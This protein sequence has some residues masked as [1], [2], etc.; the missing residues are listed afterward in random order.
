VLAAGGRPLLLDVS[1]EDCN[2]SVDAVAG[3][4]DGTVAAIVA[5]DSFGYA[6][7]HAELRELASHHGCALVEDACQSYGGMVD[8][9]PLGGQADIGVISFGTHKSVELHGGGFLLTDNRD[10]AR[11]VMHYL[12]A[13]D[14][15][16]LQWLRERIYRRESLS[17]GHEYR[18]R[19][20]CSHA[21]LLRYRFPA[22]R[23]KMAKGAWDQFLAELS[24]TKANLHCVREE[25]ESWG[26]I[27]TFRYEGVGWLPWHYSF[28]IP[29]EG[30]ANRFASQAAACGLPC[31]RNYRAM[32][33]YFP[34]LDAADGLANAH[35]IA[36]HIFNLPNRTSLESTRE[37]LP[38]VRELRRAVGA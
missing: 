36:A 15:V 17:L 20:L 32:D 19:L 22:R 35:W 9:A 11:S 24:E 33:E 29:D 26:L 3:T 21:G 6:A 37:L 2:L 5:V 1:L 8:G 34:G 4:L 27:T 25:L 28:A 18:L 7:H 14:F 16:A 13:P 10:F 31:A 30:V 23:A 38:K 12:R